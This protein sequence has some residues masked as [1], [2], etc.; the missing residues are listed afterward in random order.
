MILYCVVTAFLNAVFSL[1]LGT[2][3]FVK[4]RRNPLNVTF[5]YVSTS[6]ALWSGAYFLWQISSEAGPALMYCRI[7]SVGAFG[8]VVT[9]YHFVRHLLRLG[10]SRMTVAGYVLLGCVA[11]LAPF[12]VLVEGVAPKLMFPFWPEPG[13]LYPAY[14]GGFF[15]YLVI[16]WRPVIH[17]YRTTKLARERIQFRWVI[18]GTS[19]GIFGA[20]T[21]FLL[22]Y[23]IP[24][25]PFGN[26]LVAAYIIG[27][28]YAIIR[29]RLLEVDYAL[30]KLV[31]YVSAVLPL[32]L[33]YPALHWLSGLAG[34][35]PAQR[36]VLWLLGSAGITG[37]YFWFFRYLKDRIDKIL[38]STLLRDH[39]EG[40]DE[41]DAFSS[42]IVSLKDTEVICRETVAVV[43][44]VLNVPVAIYLREGSDREYVLRKAEGFQAGRL[45]A[46]LTEES[47]IVGAGMGLRHAV[48]L[49][50]FGLAADHQLA[51]SLD[52][53]R[54]STG[55]EL[56]IPILGDVY[57]FG[58]L[59]CGHGPKHRSFAQMDVALLE[60]V[61]G[62]IGLSLRTRQIERRANQTEKLI[63]LG[64]LAAG[65]AHE[66]RNPLVSIQTFA[67][68]LAETD[69]GSAI[70]AEFKSTVM[71]DVERIVGIVENVSAFATQDSVTLKWIFLPQV[72][73]Q[74]VEIVSPDAK[75]A[76]ISMSLE[77][78]DVPPVYANQNQLLQVAVNLLNNAVQALARSASPNVR[79]ELYSRTQEDGR[80]A[81]EFVIADN[82]PGVAP[83]ILPRIFEPFSTTKDTG[84]RFQK[85]GMGLGLAI[86]K[87]IIDGHD[88]TIRVT[89]SAAQGT[90][91]TVS[92]P[93]EAQNK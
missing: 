20:S 45:P 39:F 78:S 2:A 38:A 18:V 84:D 72:L 75:E 60:S 50:E 23:D 92:L 65:L 41:F 63:S 24:V 1:I 13:V 6:V 48:I 80:N 64:T 74:A 28:G 33:A 36:T 62:H 52:Q 3:A 87:R 25:P 90:R 89:S 85:G 51:S 86:V 66:L 93:C 37:V 82:G 46:T 29:L 58:V 44:S 40:R 22:W 53:F 61:A 43:R 55:A 70:P 76:G 35:S 49:D 68:L 27:V 4:D 56:V 34:R 17:A 19:V 67:A 30:I 26:G 32:S 21:N 15:F 31:S 79:I 69:T 5:T 14:L 42:R 8:V 9:Y 7:L 73:L 81:V 77:L 11:A 54:E 10:P 47:P 57:F 16:G 71:R 91:F 83:E 59:V 88:G 12:P